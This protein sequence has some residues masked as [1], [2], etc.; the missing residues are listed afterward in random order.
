VQ[1][2]AT[3]SEVREIGEVVAASLVGTIDEMLVSAVGY[4]KSDLRPSGAVHTTL[5]TAGLGRG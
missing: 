5:R 3:K 4:I 1:R 2:R